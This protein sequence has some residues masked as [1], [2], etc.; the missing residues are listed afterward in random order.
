MGARG[1]GR[2]R[3]RCVAGAGRRIGRRPQAVPHLHPDGRAGGSRDRRFHGRLDRQPQ[4]QPG[5]LR[6]EHRHRQARL[7]HL[8]QQGAAGQPLRHA[9]R[10][11]RQGP[12]RGRLGG[13][14]QPP[15]GRVQR[16]LRT[17]HHHRRTLQGGRRRDHQV[18]PG[19]RRQLGALGRGRR[20]RR[21]VSH[22][23]PRPERG[24]DLHGGDQQRAQP[25]ERRQPHGRLAD[26]LH[27]R[28]HVRQG[29]H[30]RPQPARR[31]PLHRLAAQRVRVDAG[32]QP[33]PR[34]VVG[35]GRPDHAAQPQDA[36]AL[37]RP[38]RAPG[39][40]STASSSPGTAAA[41][42]ASSSSPT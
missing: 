41:T 16:H 3:G 31:R 4:R 33:Q 10:D 21:A 29:Q 35:D 28:V 40:A 23:G 24:Q 39:R 2:A 38:H 26:R 36:P 11:G 27:G 13:Q 7:R 42:A 1:R 30:Q 9:L 20:R 15:H 8:H 17:R 25:G 37:V 14:A 18:V 5:H 6:Q 22:Q 19:D 34:G 32:H 12:L